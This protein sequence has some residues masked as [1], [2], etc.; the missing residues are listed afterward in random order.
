MAWTREELEA[1]LRKLDE[2]ERS[3]RQEGG[4][5]GRSSHIEIII[6]SS[7]EGNVIRG[8]AA[9][10]KVGWTLTEEE[11]AE[12]RAAA[13]GKRPKGDEEPEEEEPPKRRGY[14]G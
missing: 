11:E 13:E 4:D 3:S 12:V 6:D 14:F 8:L 10:R 1:E 9:A 2:Q 7:D 5:V